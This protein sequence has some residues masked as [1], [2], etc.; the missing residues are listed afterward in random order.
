M[1]KNLSS[2]QDGRAGRGEIIPPIVGFSGS[3]VFRWTG[4]GGGVIGA[5]FLLRG[6]LKEVFG[7]LQPYF[8]AKVSG[9][10]E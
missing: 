1:I 5:V 7:T 6:S 3:N 2:E 4:G 9:C 10:Q 8:R